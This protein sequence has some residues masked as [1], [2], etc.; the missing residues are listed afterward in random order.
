MGIRLSCTLLTLA[1]GQNVDVWPD[2]MA[3]LQ[4]ASKAE[5]RVTKRFEQAAHEAAESAKQVQK[6]ERQL[7]QLQTDRAAAEEELEDMAS[8]VHSMSA[9]TLS[10]ILGKAI[11]QRSAWRSA[12]YSSVRDEGQLGSTSMKML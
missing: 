6:L 10:R 9:C 2:S 3:H 4:A 12:V 1:T 5:A 11:L 8:Q 7:E